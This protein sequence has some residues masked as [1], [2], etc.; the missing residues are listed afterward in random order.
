MT[1]KCENIPLNEPLRFLKSTVTS[2]NCSL[3]LGTQESSLN[4]DLVDDCDPEVQSI[5]GN[6]QPT[7][8]NAVGVGAPVYFPDNANTSGMPFQFGG[9]LTNWTI[10][11]N[12][13]GKTYNAKVSDPRQLLEN[14]IIIVDSYLGPPIKGVNYFNAYSY[15][16][17]DVYTDGDCDPFGTAGSNER[18][19]PY[20]KIIDALVNID[21]TIYS[22]ATAPNGTPYQYKINFDSFPGKTGRTVPDWYRIPGPGISVLQLLQDISDVL[23]YEFYVELIKVGADN[24]I[25]VGLIDLSIAPGSF[26]GIVDSYEGVATDL[27]YG[28]ELRNEKTKM[29]LFG[30]QIHYLSRV[31]DFQFFFGEDFNPNTNK[32]QA[33]VPYKKRN[34]PGADC[35]FWIKKRIQS[36]N[37][38]LNKPLPND[39]PYEISEID[40]RAAMSSYELWRNRALDEN[41][42]GNFNKAIRDNWPDIK[43]NLNDRMNKVIENHGDAAKNAMGDMIFDPTKAEAWANKE[44]VVDDLKKIHNFIANLGN[45][46]YGKQFITPLKQTICWYKDGDEDN[47]EVYYSDLPTNAGGWIDNGPVIGLDDPE[48]GFFRQDDGRVVCFGRFN[49]EGVVDDEPPSPGES[50]PDMPPD[51]T[52]GG[53]GGGG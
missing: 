31:K 43:T 10:Q 35:G 44:E 18:G 27:S 42:P 25:T 36:L 19:M 41:S 12:N 14:T 13:S 45:T 51:Y 29:I 16:E 3:G 20:N 2:F 1:T 24:V 33:I 7:N 6:F 5:A 49:K 48:L 53:E 15:Y 4:V 26:A 8:D 37:V 47:M 32:M 28:Q 9:V 46:Y 52:G 34:E 39:G 23:A 17:E 22:P 50:N 38:T 30:E 21:P 40:I 11:Q